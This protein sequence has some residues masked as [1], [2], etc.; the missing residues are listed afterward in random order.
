MGQRSED[1]VVWQ[2]AQGQLGEALIAGCFIGVSS[3][4]SSGV[5]VVEAEVDAAGACT[6]NPIVSQKYE[7]WIYGNTRMQCRTTLRVSLKNLNV[8]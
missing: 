6:E 2:L 8:R 5:G 3:W 4:S 7:L 1:T